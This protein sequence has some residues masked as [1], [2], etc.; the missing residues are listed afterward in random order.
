MSLIQGPFAPLLAH[1]LQLHLVVVGISLLDAALDVRDS[2]I[3][4]CEDFPVEDRPFVAIWNAPT[5]GCSVNYSININLRDFDILENPMQTW[6][7][8]Y[9]TV[10]YNAQLGLYPY[11]TN[12][13]GTRSYNGGMP[14][15]RQGRQSA[16]CKLVYIV[17]IQ[18]I[19]LSKLYCFYLQNS[20]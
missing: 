8:K 6:D 9:V 3:C 4:K 16:T 5:G 18:V 14:Q 15:V 7:G 10:F 12:P 19:K 2:Y 11:F 17:F 20:V 1:L 13:E